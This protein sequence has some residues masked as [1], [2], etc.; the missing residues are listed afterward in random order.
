MEFCNHNNCGESNLQ[1]Q[2]LAASLW[3]KIPLALSISWGFLIDT[4]QKGSR[5]AHRALLRCEGTVAST[6]CWKTGGQEF[7]DTH[8]GLTGDSITTT[9]LYRISEGSPCGFG[10]L[11]TTAEL[12]ER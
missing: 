5:K 7:G 2:L 6:H 8:K 11:Q 4:I 10:E 9:A 3:S 1:N 12:A